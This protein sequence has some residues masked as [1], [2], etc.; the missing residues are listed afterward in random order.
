MAQNCNL[1]KELVDFWNS[2]D[3]YFALAH[4]SNEAISDERILMLSFI[5][6]GAKVLDVACGT[7]D[8]GAFI[9]RR[10]NRSR[11]Y[12]VEISDAALH[13]TSRDLSGK[14]PGEQTFIKADAEIIPLKDAVFDV[15]LS[16]YALEHFT[17]PRMVLDEMLR[18]CK[19]GGKIMLLSPAWDNPLSVPPS[20]DY[21]RGKAV[22]RLKSFFSQLYKGLALELNKEKTFFEIIKDPEVFRKGYRTDND[23]VYHVRVGDIRNYFASRGC[24]ILYL[25]NFED[26]A[27]AGTSDKGGIK[28]FLK[29]QFARIALFKYWSAGLFIVVKKRA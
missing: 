14:D 19:A 18:T 2:S 29:K 7:G 26:S 5:P 11:Y 1:K 3:E 15:V 12:G 6:E 22:F 28:L 20:L 4:S 13:V 24:D 16:T 10:I 17:D 25:R 9:S 23:V 21:L 8:N 27:R